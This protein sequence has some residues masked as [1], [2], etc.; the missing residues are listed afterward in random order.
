MTIYINAWLDC[1]H[2]QLTINN[3]ETGEILADFTAK[4]I[5]Q[6]F[7]AGDIT[8]EE[9][10]DNNQQTQ[11]ALIKTLFLCKITTNFKQQLKGLSNR[12]EQRPSGSVIPLNKPLGLLDL[13]TVSATILPFHHD[14][15]Q[16][17]KVSIH[18]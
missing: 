8:L 9:L 2:P 6:L 10:S 15:T 14:Y 11:Q 3:K 5:N 16:D 13:T 17:K 7:D 1:S 18:R 12:L 4:E